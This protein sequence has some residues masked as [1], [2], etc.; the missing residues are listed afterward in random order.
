MD[1]R[2]QDLQDQVLPAADDWLDNPRSGVGN[3]DKGFGSA[4]QA[5]TSQ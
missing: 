1:S 5:D 3:S 2:A 4:T